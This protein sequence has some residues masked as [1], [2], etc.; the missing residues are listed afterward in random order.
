MKKKTVKGDG[1]IVQKMFQGN[2]RQKCFK[3]TLKERI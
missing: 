3:E 1:F 2:I